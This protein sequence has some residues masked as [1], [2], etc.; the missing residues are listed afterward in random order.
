MPDWIT[1]TK[2]YRRINLI[3][4]ADFY[5]NEGKEI[6]NFVVFDPIKKRNPEV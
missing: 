1:M 6:D 3:G 4:R 2:D 5:R